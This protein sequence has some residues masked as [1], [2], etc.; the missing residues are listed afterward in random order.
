MFQLESQLHVGEW[1][2]VVHEQERATN[3]LLFSTRN[4]A[5]NYCKDE[6]EYACRRHDFIYAAERVSA[7]GWLN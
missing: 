7:M 3:F 1:R 5:V 6:L 4:F 2:S